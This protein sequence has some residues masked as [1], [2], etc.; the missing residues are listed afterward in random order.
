M[1][2]MLDDYVRTADLFGLNI[3]FDSEQEVGGSGK[4]LIKPILRT[5]ATRLA[6]TI[7]RKRSASPFYDVLADW[8]CRFRPQ[9]EPGFLWLSY[10]DK[11]PHY[12][13]PVWREMPSVQNAD[14]PGEMQRV[15][16]AIRD[17]GWSWDEHDPVNDTPELARVALPSA[18]W[19][20]YGKHLKR[21]AK[22]FNWRNVRPHTA[23]VA[24]F[25]AARAI[26]E[27]RDQPVPQITGR[28]RY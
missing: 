3:A 11:R 22:A 14:Y 15:R 24:V 9:L 4:R 12:E 28:S 16:V 10:H 6:L 26:C 17:G 21:R 25:D 5:F 8:A 13:A 2:P 20:A 23:I 7:A 1:N 19:L 27:T 18:A